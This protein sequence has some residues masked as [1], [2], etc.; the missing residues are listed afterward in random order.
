MFIAA[1]A[2]I[3]ARIV[4]WSNWP[5]FKLGSVNHIREFLFGEQYNGKVTTDGVAVRLRPK[6][7]RSLELKPLLTS[8]KRP[9]QWEIIEAM[10]Q[11]DEHDV[12]T[13]KQVLGVLMHTAGDKA[14]QVG[15]I[16]DWRYTDQMLKN[17]LRPPKYVG[18]MVEPEG[19]RKKARMVYDYNKPVKDSGGNFVYSE[20]MGK[21][22]C[23]DGRIRTHLLPITDT[24]RCKSYAPNLQNMAKSREKDYRRILGSKYTYGLRSMFKAPPGY[25]IVGAD[26]SGAE[27]MGAAI[28]SGSKQMIRDCQRG[29]LDEKDPDYY[30]IHSAVAV[31]SFRLTCPP[32][33]AG[34]KS[35][36]NPANPSDPAGS[37]YLRN[38][39]KAT[40][41]G[42]MYGRG[43]KA[44]AMAAKEEGL[45]ITIEEAQAIIDALFSMYPELPGFFAA[46]RLRVSKEKW[47][48]GCFGSWRRFESTYERSAIA[49][50][51]RQAM[52]WPMQNLVADLVYKACDNFEMYRQKTQDYDMFKFALQI[53][54]ELLFFVRIKSLDH[55]VKRVI[56][57]CM[58]KGCP[59]YP[60]DLNG[61]PTG[62][63]PYF[64]GNSV[65]V[66]Q[67][68]S[69]PMSPMDCRRLGV[70]VEYARRDD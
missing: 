64:L 23:A 47:M 9:V 52:N 38:L 70:P 54:D 59:V 37:S 66:E 42:L 33:K 26:Y 24:G 10:G 19:R 43:A 11:E 30:D 36:P 21:L 53:H 58:S 20:G 8:D 16:R 40:V 60:T 55:F 69:Q 45:D 57:A 14:E 49:D 31:L 27:L 56:P 17:F 34:L 5:E 13:G 3:Q 39:A 1:K 48:C 35:V 29:Q 46:C 32:T 4:A 12:G 44:I 51:E 62:S 7:A 2:E 65:D 15:W 18:Q 63:G 28:L 50:M 41:F 67:Y 68:W 6:T 22:I 25:V 61:F